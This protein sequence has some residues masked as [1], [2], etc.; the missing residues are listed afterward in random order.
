M[1]LLSD[2]SRILTAEVAAS[3]YESVPSSAI[4]YISFTVIRRPCAEFGAFVLCYQLLLCVESQIVAG[5]LSALPLQ[6]LYMASH[7]DGRGPRSYQTRQGKN[8]QIVELGSVTKIIIERRGPSATFSQAAILKSE[9][10]N[11][12]SPAASSPANLLT[13]PFLIMF[14]VRCLREFATPC[15]SS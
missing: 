13:C 9:A 4:S 14:T 1:C 11:F 8:E 5:H 15:E 7:S 6:P 3:G 10:T 2:P 12:A